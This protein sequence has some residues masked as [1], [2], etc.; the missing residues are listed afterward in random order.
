MIS[1]TLIDSDIINEEFKLV[2][3]EEQNYLRLT[4]KHTKDLA[5]ETLQRID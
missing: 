3:N 4:E 1:K 5:Y 2:I